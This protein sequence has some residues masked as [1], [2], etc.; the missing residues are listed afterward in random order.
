MYEIFYYNP[1]K[2]LKTGLTQEEIVNALIEE[3]S[4]IWVDMFDLDDQDI[5]FLST[6]FNLHP[7]TI[8]D[9]IMPNARPKVEK[10]KNYIF[11]I[12]F[13]L[14]KNGI[15]K[16]IELDCCL[17]KN[18]LITFHN[19]PINS[20]NISKERVKKQSPTIMHG[21]DMLLYAI[22]DTCVDSYFPII[23]DFD[24]AVD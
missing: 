12:M 21:A 19:Q 3:D 5:D 20:L 6:V 17:G 16:T 10:F 8:E 7:L 15:V 2:G 13:S 22:L 9:F 4:L 18:F 1:H 24:N 14:E 11:L 23:N